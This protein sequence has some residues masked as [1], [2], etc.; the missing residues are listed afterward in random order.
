MASHCLPH[1]PSGLVPV[2]PP[3]NEA[4]YTTL[5]HSHHPSPVPSKTTITLSPLIFVSSLLYHKWV[6]KC[7]LKF[8]QRKE[9]QRQ[10]EREPRGNNALT[11]T[12]TVGNKGGGDDMEAEPGKHR[13]KK[14]GGKKKW[15][16]IKKRKKKMQ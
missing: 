15:Y 6:P 8:G 5:L 14:Q 11:E 3:F 12:V 16:K 1:T 4:S 2:Y 10:C 9:R 13:E 7:G